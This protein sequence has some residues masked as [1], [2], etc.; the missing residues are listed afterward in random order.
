MSMAMVTAEQSAKNMEY[1]RPLLKHKQ[2]GFSAALESAAYPVRADRRAGEA[3]DRG[4]DRVLRRDRRLPGHDR[5][6]PVPGDGLRGHGPS[7]VAVRR[8]PAPR[9]GHAVR[10][11]DA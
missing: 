2:P 1:V 11:A 5:D 6:A 3:V 7:G 8:A 9:D 10:S 4:P